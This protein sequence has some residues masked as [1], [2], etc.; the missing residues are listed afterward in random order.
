MASPVSGG[1]QGAD[2]AITLTAAQGAS[3]SGAIKAP[4]GPCDAVSVRVKFDEGV[5]TAGGIQF[6]GAGR[7][8]YLQSGGADLVVSHIDPNDA[9]KYVTD[10][11]ARVEQKRE[12]VLTI[13]LEAGEYRFYLEGVEITRVKSEREVLGDLFLYVSHGPA[14]FDRVKV[15]RVE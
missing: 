2:G 7:A 3:S 11:H 9:L 1:K 14:T 12:A 10:H 6:E 15:R 4:K 13:V 8:I 5:S